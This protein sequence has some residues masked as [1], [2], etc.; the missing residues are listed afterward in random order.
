MNSERMH[1]LSRVL[2]ANVMKI[3]YENLSKYQLPKRIIDVK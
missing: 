2:D 3:W 1:K